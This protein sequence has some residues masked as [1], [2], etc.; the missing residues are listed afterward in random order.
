MDKICFI[1]KITSPSG[2]IYIGSTF[3]PDNRFQ[4]Y[5]KL[6]CKTQI[7]LLNSLAKYGYD[8]HS[9]GIVEE[10]LL[11]N[12]NE[13]EAYWGEF[14]D[15]LGK[16]GLNL[17]LPQGN[18]LYPVCREEQGKI[19]SQFMKGR[20]HLLGHKHTE[21]TKQK[22]SLKTKGQNNP[23][24]GKKHTPE[25]FKAQSERQKGLMAGEKH[26]FSKKV[27]DTESGQIWNCIKYCAE[28]LKIKY[29]TLASWLNG[30]NKN[31]SNLKHYNEE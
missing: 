10:C 15:V 27:I 31:P 3:N 6:K 19:H 26:C 20:K 4:T 30:T 21:E 5:R 22:I 1:Y 11:S 25:Q 24:F 8:N 17:R 12:R 28:E 16:Q 14:Y 9:I 18:T 13:R 7:R 29:S 23:N 2:K